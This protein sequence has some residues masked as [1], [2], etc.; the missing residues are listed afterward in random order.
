MT[1]LTVENRIQPHWWSKTIIAIVLG[2]LLS[3]GI[4]AIFAWFGPGGIDA[5]MKVQLNM[6]LISLIWLPILAL[7]YL[8]KSARSAF[9]NMLFINLIVYFILAS[10]W[11]LQ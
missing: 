10:L 2:L 8:F 5:P 6:W 1:L 4:I 11:W 7:I 9:F 3:Y